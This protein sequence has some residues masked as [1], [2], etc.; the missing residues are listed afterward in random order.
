M[1]IRRYDHPNDIIRRWH[2]TETGVT[3]AGTFAKFVAPT[4]IRLVAAYSAVSTVG[5]NTAALEQ[6]R[7]A[8]SSVGAIATG[9]QAIGVTSQIGSTGGYLGTATSGQVINCLKTGSA[10]GAAL[11]A[12]EYE[13]LPDSALA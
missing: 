7:I 4:T 2:F 6:V 9:T 1:A 12:Y 5:T 3:S 13:T 10:G 11:I 8:T